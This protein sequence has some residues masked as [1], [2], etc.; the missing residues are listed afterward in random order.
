M[1][2]TG[3]ARGVS[4]QTVLMNEPESEFFPLVQNGNIYAHLIVVKKFM[5]KRHI[6]RFD[7][8]Y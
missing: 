2:Q 6:S 4:A 3:S 1:R 8:G 5:G 7:F